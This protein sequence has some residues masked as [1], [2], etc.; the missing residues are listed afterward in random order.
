MP[1]GQEITNTVLEDLL[2]GETA[3]RTY[4]ASINFRHLDIDSRAVGQALSQLADETTF[5]ERYNTN[6]TRTRYKVNRGEP[7]RV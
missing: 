7:F 4:V 2:D 1:V 5:V 6:A 3:N